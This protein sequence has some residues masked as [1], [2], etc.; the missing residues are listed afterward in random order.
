MSQNDAMCLEEEKTT[1]LHW[2]LHNIQ[3]WLFIVSEWWQQMLC[4]T[5]EQWGRG[6]C[7]SA[8]ENHIKVSLLSLSP[9]LLLA[10]SQG[11]TVHLIRIWED[12][13]HRAVSLA[14]FSYHWLSRWLHFWI[15]R[16]FQSLKATLTRGHLTHC[17]VTPQCYCL[18]GVEGVGVMKRSRH[19]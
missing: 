15:N 16:I 9:S 2:W 6:F 13:G 4:A 19:W 7:R 14:Y 10:F 1:N 17:Q 5:P 18:V 3:I 8:S 11:Q 12:T